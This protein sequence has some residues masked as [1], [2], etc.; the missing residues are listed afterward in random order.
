[1]VA[2]PSFSTFAVE[3]ISSVAIRADGVFLACADVPAWAVVDVGAP[4]PTVV[5]SAPMAAEASARVLQV[6]AWPQQHRLKVFTSVSYIFKYLQKLLCKDVKF[7]L[8]A[9]RQLRYYKRL[10]IREFTAE[11]VSYL[12]RSTT[13]EQLIKGIR[14]LLLEAHLKP[15]KENINSCSSLLWYTLKGPGM[16]L[17][18]R[19][20]SILR[21]LLD[22]S[23]FRS[24]RQK[25]PGGEVILEVLSLVLCRLCEELDRNNFMPVWSCLLDELNS[26][27]DEWTVQ[28]SINKDPPKNIETLAIMDVD[29]RDNSCVENVE[30]SANRRGF[31]KEEKDV[32]KLV[33]ANLLALLNNLLE[34]R[35]GSQV[36]DFHPFFNLSHRLLQPSFLT[37]GEQI[38]PSQDVSPSVAIEQ[39]KINEFPHQVWRFVLNLIKSHTEL[40]G[41]SKGP[42]AIV[43]HASLWT[44]LWKCLDF[45]SL[46][47]FVRELLKNDGSIFHV[48]VP[49][50]LRIFD[51]LIETQSIHILPLTVK[52]FEKMEG[53]VHC[54]FSQNFHCGKLF[55]FV[56]STIKD[57]TNELL[58]YTKASHSRE[59]AFIWAALKCYSYIVQAHGHES[60][61]VW[62]CILAL[63][64]RLSTAHE[65]GGD[66]QDDKKVWEFLLA[67][68]LSTELKVLSQTAVMRLSSHVSDFLKLAVRYKNSAVV[69]KSVADFLDLCFSESDGIQKELVPLELQEGQAVSY[70]ETNLGSPN[71]LLRLSTLR[72]LIRLDDC[73]VDDL[74]ESKRRKNLD[75]SFS[76]SGAVTS[77]NIFEQLQSV[78]AAPFSLDAG[79]QS[80][81]V[82]NRL[83]VRACTE[84]LPERYMPFLTHAMVGVMFNR[85]G[86]LWDAAVDCLSGLLETRNTA[87]WEIFTQH[88]ALCQNKFLNRKEVDLFKEKADDFTE[89]S[90]VS[91]MESYLHNE[92]ES[93]DVGTTVTL[94]LK[95]VQKVPSVAEGRTRQLIPLFLIFIGQDSETE[96]S[97]NQTKST[98]GGKDWKLVLKEW[99]A[100]LSSMKNA[101]SYFKS[102]A[103]K[104]I[105][106]NRFLMDANPDIQLKVLECVLNWKDSYLTPYENH[107]K[108]LISPKMAREEMTT[109]K[110][111]K[112]GESVQPNHRNGLVGILLRVL[113]PKILKTKTSLHNKTT[114]GIQRK[115]ILA[116]LASL[117][118]HELS[119]FFVLILRPLESAFTKDGMV[120]NQEDH[121]WEL[122]VKE[123]AQHN[124]IEWVDIEGTAKLSPKKKIG[125]LHMLKDILETFDKDHLVPYLH[126]CL[127]FTF[128]ILQTC[129]VDI[130]GCRN[131]PTPRSESLVELS[132]KKDI[133]TL[134][135]KVIAIVLSKYENVEFTPIY[136][137]SFFGTVRP[138]IQRFAE[139]GASGDG[140][141]ALF[142]C[143][144]A[145]SR[146]LALVSILQ[147]KDK[148]VP[149]LLPL[150]SH[151]NSSTSVVGA[152]LTFV[153]N[154]LALEE[155]EVGLVAKYVLPH[156]PLLLSN[157]RALLSLQQKRIR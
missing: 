124:F 6:A 117:D 7:I 57:A 95:A 101:Q 136:W 12:L 96:R 92:G 146:S 149:N 19:A 129:Q 104:E 10:F 84:N 26:F 103:V 82:F 133:R 52:L 118:V 141:S 27:L 151:K 87:V 86:L 34:F 107:L 125:F 53:A 75:G 29:C 42:G 13:N 68:A 131:A 44:Q 80:S 49:D 56:V 90:P 9:T 115:V 83:K 116:F 143:F 154:I 60:L 102:S 1:M 111:E 97:S 71:K 58:D 77:E 155:E 38:I 36:H 89:K 130:V 37:H 93:T 17:H 121:A 79:R 99:I 139:E 128:R 91:L 50:I 112:E 24:L 153:E 78:E 5:M 150:L 43:S 28:S 106:V 35:K 45:S 74:F 94:L 47:Y 122:A 73:S 123:G 156:L 152:A 69:L 63:D 105:L 85:F 48:F 98:S 67:T 40:T 120:C 65:V 51:G 127:A 11:A 41:A 39:A 148:I 2:S 132:G 140:P 64:Q 46:L 138:M 135:L 21:L 147:K 23:T 61:L 30:Q 16:T 8:K 3:F 66:S 4:P 109:W 70:L 76:K 81:L 88:L 62:N 108:N 145:M 31:S 54:G 72:L 126:A 157:L 142:S 110:I 134:C 114:S 59:P 25:D 32:D 20:H 33:I 14:K 100:L 137:D 113:F 18:S 55:S 22:K 144:L 15:S 119:L